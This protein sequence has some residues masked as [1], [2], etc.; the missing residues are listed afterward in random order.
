LKFESRWW[1]GSV[2][3]ALVASCTLDR[4]PRIDGEARRSGTLYVPMRSTVAVPKNEVFGSNPTP[5]TP[6]VQKPTQTVGGLQ[7]AG[8]YCPFAAAPMKPCCTSAS[9]V[10]QGSA[11]D[12]NK[13]GV[14]FSG[15]AS[16]FYGSADCWQSDQLG[17]V[18]DRCP[19]QT[20][21]P[22]L[23][24]P[25]C[26][27][28]QGLCGSM[29]T[30]QAIGCHYQAGVAPKQCGMKD[31]KKDTECT[32]IGTYGIRSTVD[33]SWGGR[34]GGL[35]GLTDDGRASIVINLMARI[36]KVDDGTYALHGT[37]RPC[38]V[39]LP[40]FYSTTLCES[41]KP[42][43]PTK[44][45][46]SDKLPVVPLE[47]KL[48]CPNPGCIMTINAQTVLLGIE[49]EN[50]E[51]PW[52]TS[53]DTGTLK[54]PSGTGVQCFIDHDDDMLPGMTIQL[55][56]MGMAP[57][58]TGC[59]GS[60]AYSAAPL[61]SS[62]AAIFGG[63]RRADR[64]LLGTRTKLGGSGKIAAD[65]DSGV[66]SGIA[67]FVQSRSWGCYVQQGSFNLGQNPAGP[68][69]ACAPDEAQFLDDNLPIYNILNVG[70]T[71]DPKLN[72]VDKSASKGPLFSIV[73]LGEL[74]DPVTC[75]DVRNAH[76]Q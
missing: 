54:C 14:D 2:S 68:N 69:E 34:S 45:W 61:S 16:D 52:P 19:A 51:A 62:P 37:V 33:V 25:G 49:L 35:V 12:A 74:G 39:E 57:P 18:D 70:D 29:N 65:C 64:V 9:D 38:N 44:I 71:P 59:N 73:R 76:Y 72:V 3:L 28:D 31:I 53:T 60:Y 5:T 23:E 24:E 36:D 48:E 17:V 75:A 50:P 11:R 47:G 22:G 56:T 30:G 43:F 42:V 21:D 55:L 41:Y 13:C 46:E 67:Q 15:T 1:W 40:P 8:V 66:G 20:T 63:V 7:C 4:T 6:M 26:C 10:K 27:S 58:G 32:T